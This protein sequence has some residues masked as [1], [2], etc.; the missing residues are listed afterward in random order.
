LQLREEFKAHIA[1]HR[2]ATLWVTHDETE[3]RAMA[4]RGYR[5]HEGA[6]VSLW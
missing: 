4:A 6:L 5:L 2:M 1:E 3:A